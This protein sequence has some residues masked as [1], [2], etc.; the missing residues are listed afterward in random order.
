MI[1]DILPPF[2]AACDVVGTLV[3]CTLFPQEEAAVARA[4][5]KRRQEFATGR[6]CARKAL[7]KLNVGAGAIV[8]GPNREP[9]WP[10][11]I[12]GSITHCEGYCAAAVALSAS[13]RTIGI[14]AELNEP[15]PDSV[16]KLIMR[17]DEQK[18][19]LEL[20]KGQVCWDRLLFSIKE[21]IYKAWFSVEQHWLDF[22]EA[23]VSIA[24]EA[25]T[26]VAQ[27]LGRPANPVF[28]SPVIGKFIVTRGVMLTSLVI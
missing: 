19:L 15:L 4:V 22:A 5:P 1:K 25:D 2:V 20:P 13:V 6:N 23:R 24:P 12:V 7:A 27:I 28:Q 18:M 17:R 21:S 11:G 8:P 14:D 16:G 26:F 9:M 10:S 3:E